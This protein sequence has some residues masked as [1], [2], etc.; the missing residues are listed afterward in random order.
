MSPYLP[1]WH[2]LWY[3]CLAACAEKP[4]RFLAK[5]KRVCPWT[6]ENV[7]LVSLLC[8]ANG[9]VDKHFLPWSA[10]FVASVCGAQRYK[11]ANY[12]MDEPGWGAGWGAT[13][14]SA[15]LSIVWRYYFLDVNICAAFLC[16]CMC[17]RAPAFGGCIQNM[18]EILQQGGKK[19]LNVCSLSVQTDKCL[20]Y[21]CSQEVI[22]NIAEQ[23][24]QAHFP[25]LN[26]QC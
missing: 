13:Y 11:R 18:E 22:P 24:L 9:N 26:L 20:S 2:Y 25:W 14:F 17:V 21:T 12:E 5:M 23:F 10:C 6:E 16:V 3:A 4:A 1:A 7:L 19:P 15:F 8:T